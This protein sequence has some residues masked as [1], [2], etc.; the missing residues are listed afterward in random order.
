M[1]RY[2]LLTLG[3]AAAVL[4]GCASEI[5]KE[6]TDVDP[7]FGRAVRQNIA[8]QIADPAPVYDYENP[9]ASGG[10][11]TAAA[12]DRYNKGQVTQPVPQSTSGGGKGN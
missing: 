2:A 8:A 10:E 9:P 12:Q 3:L 1:M 7:D 11:R 6:A 4:G 5:H